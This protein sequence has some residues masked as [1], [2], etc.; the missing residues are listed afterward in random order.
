MNVEKKLIRD[1]INKY[2][3]KSKNCR[4]TRNMEVYKQKLDYYKK[5]MVGG[6]ITKDITSALKVLN[7]RMREHLKKYQ[8]SVTFI[9]T[10]KAREEAMIEEV[11]EGARAV[12]IEKQEKELET[13][14]EENKR[15][16]QQIKQSD[17]ELEKAQSYKELLGRT[18]SQLLG[19][20][21]QLQSELETITKEAEQSQDQLNEKDDK[22]KELEGK[23]EQLE[24][25]NS[26]SKEECKKDI[27][28]SDKQNIELSN[29]IKA[30]EEGHKNQETKYG[31][32]VEQYKKLLPK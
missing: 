5:I 10:E 6:G 12:G 31:E 14:R 11:A 8:E 32:L 23:I 16:L 29:K 3:L 27:D 1:K 19:E 28:K 25:L 21:S 30:M 2:E 18:N 24:D 26:K 7:E 22:I 4:G 13:L 20:L 17:E 9:A 15:L